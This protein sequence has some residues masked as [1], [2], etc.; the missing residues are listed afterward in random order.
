MF[1]GD[2]PRGLDA[3]SR[4]G[5]GGD[6]W[7][8]ET[9]YLGGDDLRTKALVSVIR[10]LASP[11][12]DQIAFLDRLD[13]GVEELALQFTDLT[14]SMPHGLSETCRGDLRRLDQLLAE[15]SEPDRSAL[16]VFDA[17]ESAPEWARVRT[18]AHTFLAD[19][20]APPGTGRW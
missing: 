10:R 3:L 20:A 14:T 17:L 11:A 19:L 1:E 9:V 15:I 8:P 16:L 18:L 13:V 5:G 2:G 12:A 4:V 7:R 6:R